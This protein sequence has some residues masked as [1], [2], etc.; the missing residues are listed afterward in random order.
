MKVDIESPGKGDDAG[1]AGAG[2]FV[3]L[4]LEYGGGLAQAGFT[5]FQLTGPA[6]R[7]NVLPFPGTF[8][9]GRDERLPGLAVLVSRMQAFSGPGTNLANLFNVT[10]VTDRKDDGSA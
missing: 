6:G 2:W 9:P 1:I 8:S 10:G 5:G 4:E 3:D 7:N